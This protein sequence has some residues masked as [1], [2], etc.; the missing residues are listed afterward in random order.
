MAGGQGKEEVN[1]TAEGRGREGSLIIELG[2][3]GNPDGSGGMGGGTWCSAGEVHGLRDDDQRL[4]L[5][6]GE[7]GRAGWISCGSWG[8]GSGRAEGAQWLSG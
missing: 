1:Y 6:R 4:P 3:H 5:S 8:R 2:E 7:Q